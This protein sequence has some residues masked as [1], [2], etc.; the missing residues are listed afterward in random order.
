MRHD[1]RQSWWNN[2][3]PGAVRQSRH[4]RASRLIAWAIVCGAAIGHESTVQAQ[5]P[6]APQ[7]L[8]VW[9]QSQTG[10]G[11]AA[12]TVDVALRADGTLVGRVVAA[13]QDAR[14]QGVAGAGIVL[15]TQSRVIAQ[16]A[17]DAEGRFAV[18]GLSGG[19]YELTAHTPQG[20]CHRVCR[21]WSAS[22][23]PPSALA[24]IEL[25][26]GQGNLLVLGQSP[27]PVAGIGRVATIT[28]IVA[29]AIAVPVVYGTKNTKWIPA[30]P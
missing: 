30:S 22:A 5:S 10:A 17:A 24:E 3:T 6:I 21:L 28:G 9:A 19:V 20:M 23:A 1:P 25:V 14:R 8:V 18:P 13:G 27:F 4:L 11:R 16:T 12:A 2:Q 7:G 29:G 26:G 15:R